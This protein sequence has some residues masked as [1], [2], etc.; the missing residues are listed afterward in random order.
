MPVALSTKTLGEPGRHQ[1]KC[2]DVKSSASNWVFNVRLEFFRTQFVQGGVVLLQFI[3]DGALKNKVAYRDADRQ[4]CWQYGE[5]LQSI[6]EYRRKKAGECPRQNHYKGHELPKSPW[7]ENVV[8]PFGPVNQKQLIRCTGGKT[9][10]EQCK[11]LKSFIVWNLNDFLT[12]LPLFICY[13]I[14]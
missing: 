2:N 1:D 11:V 10:Q 8:C 6:W 9:D 5:I 14:R 7:F 4:R 12:E 13:L 3:G